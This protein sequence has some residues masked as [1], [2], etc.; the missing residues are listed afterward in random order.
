MNKR[1]LNIESGITNGGT[2]PPNVPEDCSNN[3]NEVAL[4]S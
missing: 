2:K 3:S 1:S 4:S